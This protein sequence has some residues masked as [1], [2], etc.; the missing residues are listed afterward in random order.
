MFKKITFISFALFLSLCNIK[1][2]DVI[3]ASTENQLNQ[4]KTKIQAQQKIINKNTESLKS[5]ESII[6]DLG[7]EITRLKNDQ[8]EQLQA[9]ESKTTSILEA[10]NA[11][12]EAQN[13]SIEDL[14]ASINK[15]DYNLYVYIAIA[16][17]IAL[18]LFVYFMKMATQKAITQQGKNWS[19]F[20]TYIVKR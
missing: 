9:F 14:K 2:Q 19:D 13:K 4:L 5:H 17:G 7:A 11:K 12:I 15:K 1:A 16:L 10:Y 18:V 8:V 6:A 20:L 3:S